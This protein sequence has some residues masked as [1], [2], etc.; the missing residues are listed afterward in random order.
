MKIKY[1]S[2]FLIIA[3]I[4]TLLFSFYGITGSNINN[5]YSSNFDSPI[6]LNGIP[7]VRQPSDYS[8]G[9]T[10]LQAVLNYYGIDKKVDDII[11]LTHSSPDQ[12]TAPENIV[13]AARQFGLNGEIKEGLTIEDLQKYIKGKIP[14]IIDCQ[15]WANQ[16]DDI[17]WT[18]D[19]ED[20]HYMVVIGVDKDNIYFEDPAILG[21]RGIIPRYEF[22]D[23][24]HDEYIDPISGQNK[25]TYHMGIIITGK[26]PGP[27]QVVMEV[28]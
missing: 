19:I 1:S 20:G 23:R 17:N 28:K 26:Q 8:C 9:P 27:R 14:V 16:H 6:F 11:N 22:L 25:T 10:S 21:S 5:T 13:A 2:L 4:L 24:W 3:L 12:G 18:Q 7:D 15:A